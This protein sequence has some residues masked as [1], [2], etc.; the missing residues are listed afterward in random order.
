MTG[1][2]EYAFIARELIVRTERHLVVLMLPLVCWL[3]GQEFPAQA[4]LAWAV[5]RGTA[6]LTTPRAAARA[7][8]NIGIS[9][10]PRGAFDEINRSQI[11]RRLNEVVETGAPGFI[12]EGA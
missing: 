5:Q 7:R 6:L 9:R 1:R 11:R 4:L 2:V 3:A 12:P 8:E 10:T